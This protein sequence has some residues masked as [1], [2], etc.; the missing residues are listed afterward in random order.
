MTND[1]KDILKKQDEIL[2]ELKELNKNFK[3]V[4]EVFFINFKS[5]IFKSIVRELL[6]KIASKID[7]IKGKI[8]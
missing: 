3:E 2:N 8:K 6:D 5:S 1:I 4:Q 7:D